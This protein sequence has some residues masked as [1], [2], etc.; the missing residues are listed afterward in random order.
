MLKIIIQKKAVYTRKVLRGLEQNG[1]LE[2]HGNSKND[3][4]QYFTFKYK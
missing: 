4:T 1:Y 2:W 3:P